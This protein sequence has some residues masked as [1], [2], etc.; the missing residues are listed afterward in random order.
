VPQ[1]WWFRWAVVGLGL[2]L[3]ILLIAHR[4]AVAGA[5]VMVA[6]VVRAVL[7]VAVQRRRANVRQRSQRWFDPKS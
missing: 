7:L 6:A 1:I 4:D 5:L 2:L 3:G